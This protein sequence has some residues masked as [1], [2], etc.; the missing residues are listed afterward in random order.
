MSCLKQSLGQ[1]ESACQVLSAAA[2]AAEPT[3]T[4]I[5]AVHLCTLCYHSDGSQSRDTRLISRQ[6]FRRP[7]LAVLIIIIIIIIT[8][9]YSA[10]T[11]KDTEALE[12]QS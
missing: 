11:S 1:D 4:N 3:V 8:D 6:Y 12:G 10:F 7:V 5:S 9:L 2:A